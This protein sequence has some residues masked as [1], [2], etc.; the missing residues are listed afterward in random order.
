MAEWHEYGNGTCLVTHD[1]VRTAYLI[2]LLLEKER[3]PRICVDDVFKAVKDI[4]NF[5]EVTHTERDENKPS[6]PK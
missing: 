2:I 5:Q 3:V 1:T 6:F 4:L